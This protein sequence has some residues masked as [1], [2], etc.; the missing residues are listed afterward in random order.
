MLAGVVSTQA[1]KPYKY[2]IELTDKAHSSYSIEKPEA[3]LSSRAIERRVKRGIAIDSTDLPVS[4]TYVKQLTGEGGRLVAVS[5]W[6]NTVLMEVPDEQTAESF[7]KHSFVKAIKKV[8][9]APDSIVA[10]NKNRKKEVTNRLRKLDDYYGVAGDQIRMHRGDSLH[11]AGFKGQGMQVAV[12]DAG[13]YNVD[14]IKLFKKMHVSGTHD[15]VNARS[16]I[17]EEHNHGLKVLSCM[18]ANV[19]NAMVGTAPEASYWLLRSEDNDTEQPVEEDYWTAAVEF[20]DSVGVDVINT[21]L[22]YYEFDNRAD[23]YRYR[24]LTGHVSLMSKTASRIADKGM[25]LVCSAGNAGNNTWKKISPPADAENVMVVGAVDEGGVNANFSS[26]GNTVDGR[27]RPDVMASG[28]RV[29][30]AGTDGGTSFANGTSFSSPLF[31]GLAT[32]LWQ[33]CPWLSVREL[34]DII[35]RAS[36]RADYPDNIYGYGITDIWKAYHLALPLKK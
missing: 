3:Y 4:D 13:F 17:Y 27:I 14:V 16:D 6:N 23:D 19:P 7:R 30:V 34:I 25:L 24:D 29:N 22:G 28:V 32:C 36:D 33:A 18:A 21:S 10:R 5:K 9:T 15:F 2:R 20:A 31:C 35:H 8:W 1:Q 12:I 26:V 11:L